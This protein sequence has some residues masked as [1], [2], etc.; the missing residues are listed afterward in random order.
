MSHGLRGEDETKRMA[1]TAFVSDLRGRQ[2][3]RAFDEEE[4]QHEDMVWRTN[5]LRKL[6]LTRE[7]A[8]PGMSHS[9]A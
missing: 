8:E 5:R 4:R 9:E 3:K 6:R 1:G 2:R 7:A